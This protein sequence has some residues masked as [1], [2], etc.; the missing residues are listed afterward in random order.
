MHAKTFVGKL[1]VTIGEYK[2]DV[3]TL[4]VAN[5]TDAAL[6]VLDRAAQSYYGDP[7]KYAHD[8][9]GY[10]ANGGEVHVG[11]KNLNEIG[12]AAFLE[13]K[14]TLIVR[15]ADNVTTPGEAALTDSFQGVA[16]A[17]VNALARKSI[18]VSQSQLLHALAT[19]VG[20]KNWHVL[21]GKLDQGPSTTKPNRDL[22]EAWAKREGYAN[23]TRMHGNP[24]IY[25]DVFLR[26][27]YSG[28]RADSPAETSLTKMP[29]PTQEKGASSLTNRPLLSDDELYLMLE[30]AKY[31][32]AMRQIEGIGSI[33]NNGLHHGWYW[34]LP[35]ETEMVTDEDNHNYLG[36]FTSLAHL[37]TEVAAH[38]D[39]EVSLEPSPL[40]EQRRYVAQEMFE[41]IDLSNLEASNGWESKGNVM[42]RVYFVDEGKPDTVRRKFH[43]TFAAGSAEP[44]EVDSGT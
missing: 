27:A 11:A 3:T 22:F 6:D 37:L 2:N 7:A 31:P 24:D 28:Y 12:L 20:A 33:R 18:E 39:I 23:F 13:L 15:K 21:K 44:I 29:S 16:R 19:A 35:F 36:Y 1:T 30:T 17:L 38:L 9:E 41:S 25:D 10:Y 14:Q 32:H 43:V 5:S 42:K 40:D 26:H 34:L 4:I 8:P